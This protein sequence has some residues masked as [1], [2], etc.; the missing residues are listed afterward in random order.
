MWKLPKIIS[1]NLLLLFCVVLPLSASEDTHELEEFQELANSLSQESYWNEIEQ[2]KFWTNSVLQNLQLNPQMTMDDS[3][4]KE[5]HSCSNL[6]K[7]D[8]FVSMKLSDQLKILNL[9]QRISMSLIQNYLEQQTSHSDWQYSSLKSMSELLIHF[10]KLQ[11]ILL[12]II[13]SQNQDTKIAIEQLSKSITDINTLKTNLDLCETLARY[14]AEE[15]NSLTK[16]YKALKRTRIT[17]LC[18][19]GTGLVTSLLGVTLSNTDTPTNI[20]QILIVGGSTMMLGSG[21]TLG[22]SITLPL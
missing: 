5:L 3:L 11:T 6:M 7:S 2:V 9:S 18:V 17:S 1:L 8:E 22:L 20:S 15:I 19:F 10:E 16:K 14:Q 13:K 4:L 21:L 12:K